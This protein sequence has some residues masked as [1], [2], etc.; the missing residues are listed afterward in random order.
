MYFEL[1]FDNSPAARKMIG[2]PESQQRE[3]YEKPINVVSVINGKPTVETKRVQQLSHT[4]TKTIF[5]PD[6]VRTIDEQI[7][8]I[9]SDRKESSPAKRAQR[10]KI[11]GDKI[12]I[13]AN[14]VWTLSEF[15]AWS[16]KIL[17]ELMQNGMAGLT[18]KK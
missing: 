10:W 14:T 7:E 12:T 18:K 3:L 5:A 11:E 16:K 9:K 4:E 8:F 13:L 6:H 15:E 2:F 1:L 17:A